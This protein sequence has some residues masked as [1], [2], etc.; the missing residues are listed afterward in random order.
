MA[1]RASG[2]ETGGTSQRLKL[3]TDYAQAIMWSKG[4][5]AEETEAAFARVQALATESESRER[6]SAY[7]AQ[8]VGSLHRGE[9]ALARK[10]AE[11]FRGESLLAT[12][13]R[14]EEGMHRH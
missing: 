6:F 2:G 4:F 1:D 11:I 9:L 12:L 3:Q 5:A 14:T 7:Y 8:C 13:A 10:T